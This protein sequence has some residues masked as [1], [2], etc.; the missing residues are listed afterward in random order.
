[1]DMQTMIEKIKGGINSELLLNIIKE[2]APRLDTMELLYERYKTEK[3]GTP[4]FDRIYE[5]DGTEQTDKINNKLNNDF[6][7]E[8]I[9][10]K[11]G[12][13]V[14]KPINYMLDKEKVTKFE[15]K[16]DIIDRFNKM[17]N[18]ADL[19]G[20]TAK[21]AAM[22]GYC[23][24]LAYIEYNEPR[25]GELKVKII[26][27]WNCI[28][29]YKEHISEPTYAVHFRGEKF[30]SGKRVLAYKYVDIYDSTNMTTYTYQDNKTYTGTQPIAH[31]IGGVPL[32][33]ISN[34]DELIG[35]AEK[36]LTLIDAYDRTLSD[37]DNE[38]EQFRLAY[39][40]IIGATISK[41][42]LQKARQTG[43]FNVPPGA[44]IDFI[45]K[46]IQVEA[47]ENMLNRL[48]AN[49]TRFSKHVNMTD[50]EFAGNQS[51]VALKYKMLPLESKCIIAERKFITGLQY[52]YQLSTAFWNTKIAGIGF[53]PLEI[54][55][56]FTRNFPLNLVEE[57]DVAA[58][59]KGVISDR[60]L[61]SLLT[62]I[63]D[64]D[65]ELEQMKAE[66]EVKAEQFTPIPE[67]AGGEEQEK[68]ETEQV[69]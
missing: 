46:Q 51:G 54:D 56:I 45:M 12:Y 13:F 32:F 59:F 66:A 67:G 5:I 18:I 40:K 36:V 9:D 19:D 1:M 11:I 62:F 64:P 15:E 8:I 47:L 65:T 29:L 25:A 6:F 17:N 20:E 28:I 33:G 26:M 48:E 50:K 63:D 24:R 57:G 7:S 23:G 4:I 69:A 42:D 35:D 55:F 10:T 58:K 60:T 41:E 31:K 38:L 49:I 22:C 43:A 37:Y 27:P 14:G 3:P 30:K 53:D 61:L 21:I 2:Y 44:D 52:Q 34:N 68:P 39:M 16:R